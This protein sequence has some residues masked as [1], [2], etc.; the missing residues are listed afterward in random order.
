MRMNVIFVFYLLNKH[1]RIFI[2]EDVTLSLLGP[3]F[4]KVHTNTQ[5]KEL[6]G[7]HAQEL[8]GEV[9]K[10]TTP[11]RHINVAISGRS[12]GLLWQQYQGQVH[13]KEPSGPRPT[14]PTQH[15]HQ[16]HACVELDPKGANATNQT[17]PN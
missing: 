9:L 15:P 2:D 11:K 1:A 17:N 16:D 10:D 7:P 4:C 13:K 8:L 5:I 3:Q 12:C 14:R 6:S